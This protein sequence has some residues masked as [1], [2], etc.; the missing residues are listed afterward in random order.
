MGI[1]ASLSRFA[2]YCTR[3]GFWATIQ[4]TGLSV[5]RALLSGRSVLFYCDL[6]T[7]TGIP[8]GLPSFVKVERKRGSAEL[9]P[10][11]LEE[12]TS[13]WN[14]KLAKRNMKE[15]FGKGSSL[16][17][18]KSFDR[19]AGY[20]WTLQGRT[21]E[22]HYFPLGHDDVHFFDFHVFPQYRG[23][24]MNPLL[25]TYILQRLAAEGVGR[26]LIEA[27][28]WNQA[29]LS[30]LSKTPFRRLGRAKKVTIFGRTIV[31]WSRGEMCKD[32]HRKPML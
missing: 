2:T 27:A 10:E 18:I 1:P 32:M 19:L 23:R 4:R 14:P 24:G 8:C 3:H 26:A 16:W 20:G 30:S 13:F 17:L 12:M 21:I 7:Q 29:Q 5:R 31:S 25:V 6:D 11:D 9:S 28:E 22:P 15:R